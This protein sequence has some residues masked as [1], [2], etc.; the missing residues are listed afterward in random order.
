[1]GS[2]EVL[3]VSYLLQA[4]KLPPEDLGH[5]TGHLWGAPMVFT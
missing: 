5:V 2:F 3:K 1:M 4:F